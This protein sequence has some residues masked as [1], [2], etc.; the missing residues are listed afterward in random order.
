SGVERAPTLI[1]EIR[2][3]LASKYKFDPEDTEA[4]MIWD[5]TETFKF[6]AAF[7]LAFRAFLVGI[8]CLTLITGGI[9]VTNIMN[10]VLEERTKEIGVKMAVGARKS[11]IMLQ[12][13]FETGVLTIIGGGLGFLLAMLVI[14]AYPVSL[15]EYLGVPVVNTY[16]AVFAILVLGIVALVSGIFPARRAANLEPVKALK[17]F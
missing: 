7:F 15:I 4:L 9:G 5:T 12:F 13:L 14:W 17:L 10:V 2:G 16:G 1:R 3:F 6:F 8:G 11:T